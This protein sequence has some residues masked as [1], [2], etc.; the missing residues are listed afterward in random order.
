MIEDIS[1]VD[2]QGK[3]RRQGWHVDKTVSISHVLT[4]VTILIAGIWYMVDQDKRIA[5]NAQN[6]SH[7]L[8]SI[9][10]QE[11]RTNRSLDAIHRKLDKLTDIALQ[12][13]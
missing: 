10:Q 12:R 4:T 2:Y 8:E 1:T 9:K 13:K 6:I 5:A 7:N 3:E 11:N